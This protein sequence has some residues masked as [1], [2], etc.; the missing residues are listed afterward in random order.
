MTDL[1]NIKHISDNYLCSNCGACSFICPNNA[2]D[3]KDT[4]LGRLYASVNDYCVQCGLCTKVCPSIDILGIY[5]END[6]PLVG[7]INKVYVGKCSDQKLFKNAQSG[8]AA[9]AIISYLLD[10]NKVEAALVCVMEANERSKGEPMVITKSMDVAKSQ[11]SCYTPVPLLVGLKNA[12]KYKKIAVIGLP[13][14]IEALTLLERQNKLS[15]LIYKV[16]LICDRMMC[17]TL[18]DVMMSLSHINSG[19]IDWRRKDFSYNK[20]YYPYKTAPVVVY[21]KKKT[22]VIPNSYR[23]SLKEMFTPPRC[24]LCY[25]KLNTF[26]DVTVGDPWGMS[27]VDWN[28]GASLI[29]TRTSLGQIL[30]AEMI[31]SGVLEV[32]ER[33]LSEVID[34]QH[35]NARVSQIK[36]FSSIMKPFIAHSNSFLFDGCCDEIEKKE[37]YAFL[38]REFSRFRE[39]EKLDKKEIISKAR[40]QVYYDRFM[41]ELYLIKGVFDRLLR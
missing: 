12:V 21:D 18:A 28:Q 3:F 29:L 36:V 10:T 22:K 16:G 25:D 6:N 4:S 41:S 24:R 27:G 39:N 20:K 9:S 17:G 31:N 19:K 15:N 38:S 26:A 40:K 33:P 1:N 13:C 37:T 7:K 5:K 34:G 32:T 23:F 14:Q 30:L 11:K 2:I 35:I 8:G